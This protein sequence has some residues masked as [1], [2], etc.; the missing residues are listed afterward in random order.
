[1]LSSE[2]KKK[3]E[4]LKLL[5]S[6]KYK[7]G[8][9]TL[10]LKKLHGAAIAI[11]PNQLDIPASDVLYEHHLQSAV[12]VLGLGTTTQIKCAYNI[13]LNQFEA[14]LFNCKSHATVVGTYNKVQDNINIVS[15]NEIHVRIPS[16]CV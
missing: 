6:K 11:T 12:H 10:S 14:V 13:S 9:W 3:T 15:A 5:H 16:T 1:M 2:E 4:G 8:N 7:S